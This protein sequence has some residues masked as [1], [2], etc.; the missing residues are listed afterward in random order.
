MNAVEE[1]FGDFSAEIELTLERS[2][3]LRANCEIE[4]VL[5]V[6]MMGRTLLDLSDVNTFSVVLNIPMQ[7]ALSAYIVKAKT[8]CGIAV[9]KVVIN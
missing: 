1:V 4:E 2:G 3:V 6:D 7:S 9:K 8:S 5:V